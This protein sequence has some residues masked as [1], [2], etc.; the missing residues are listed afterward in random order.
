[1]SQSLEHGVTPV[2]TKV[3]NLSHFLTNSARR[4]ANE[5]GF[6]WGTR[7]WR[8]Q[9]MEA[10]SMAFA[11]ALDKQMG[12]RK[13]DRLLVQSSNCHQM[14]EAMFAC[15]RIGAIWVPANYR[16][17]PEEIAWLAESS[18][19]KGLL[20]GAQFSDHATACA[21]VVD[22]TVSIGQSNFADDYDTLVERFI[23]EEIATCEVNRDDPA[24]LFFTSGTT[25]KP[26]AAILT[27]GQMAF[28]V[29]NHLCDLMPGTNADDASIVVAPLSHGAGVHQLAQ[30][31]SGVKTILPAEDKFNPES[32][33]AL[34]EKW[35]VTNLFTVPTI[36]KMLIEHPS[37]DQY[38]HASLRYVVYAG[39]PMYRADQVKALEKLGPVLVQYF[40]LGEV[41]GNITVLPPTFH[42]VEDQHMKTGSCGFTRTGMQV[43]IQNSEGREVPANETGEIAVIGPAVFAGY[44]DNPEANRKSFRNGW[45]LTGDLGH[46]DEEGFV[47]LTGRVSDMY[48]SGGSNIYP[49]E[50]EEKLLTHPLVSEAAVLGVPDPTWGEVG[51][52]VC[53]P[54]PGKQLDTESLN[55]WLSEKISR[56]KVPKNYVV[57]DEMPK[58]AY[59]KI[60]K[61][62]IR[63]TLVA[64]G[65]IKE[66][67]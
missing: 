32:I 47:Y 67:S 2:S 34:V 27:H 64:R 6:V 39:A 9:E 43:Q 15:W 61:K 56:Y 60:T 5:I 19:A 22:F 31:A 20:C 42:H 36:V 17:S 3:M 18:G 21:P 4:L 23:G 62:L 50:I 11:Y 58:T 24:W 29:T 16:Q 53:V 1:M 55:Q 33:W 57:W 25:G 41:T 63:E 30:V 52:A 13:G 14:F 38:N 37:V 45:F 10:R 8:W 54:Y 59:G 26:K 44:F 51:M 66:S 40:G 49:R 7:T 46:M 35:N 48:I 12:L 65:E 28:V